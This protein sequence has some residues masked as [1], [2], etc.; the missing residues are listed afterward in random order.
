MREAS[1]FGEHV[2][3]TREIRTALG[4]NRLLVQDRVENLGPRPHPT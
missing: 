1:V 3:L 4:W 2:L